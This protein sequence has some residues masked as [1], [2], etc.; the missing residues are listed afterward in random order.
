MVCPISGG[1]APVARDTGFLNPL[2]GAG[3]KTGGSI[4]AH[5]IESLDWA[6]RKASL[7]ERAPPHIVDQVI[8]CLI[9]VLED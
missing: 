8:E 6:V 9:S 4:H 3:L 5:Q 1:A 7:V 2:P